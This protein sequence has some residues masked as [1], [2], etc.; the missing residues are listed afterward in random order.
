[1]HKHAICLHTTQDFVGDGISA[2]RANL[3]GAKQNAPARCARC[4]EGGTKAGLGWRCHSDP[5]LDP[6]DRPKNWTGPTHPIKSWHVSD[7]VA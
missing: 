5:Y 1:M 7:K 3:R 6:T 4:T 2:V